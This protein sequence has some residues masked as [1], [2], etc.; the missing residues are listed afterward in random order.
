MRHTERAVF[1]FCPLRPLLPA[2]ARLTLT[3]FMLS[4]ATLALTQFAAEDC[5]RYG[6]LVARS[7]FVHA[8]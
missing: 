1:S 3:F 2:Q 5:E 6:A 8:E 7:P 4:V